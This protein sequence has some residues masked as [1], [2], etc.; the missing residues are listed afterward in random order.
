M[1]WRE[2]KSGE[3]SA[4]DA[5]ELVAGYLAHGQGRGFFEK[6]IGRL[7]AI[8][9]EALTQAATF[10]ADNKASNP[11]ITTTYAAVLS[12]YK[13]LCGVV[14]EQREADGCATCGGLGR[15]V[16]V[17][18]GDDVFSLR[19]LPTGSEA[20]GFGV[21]ATR[22]VPCFCE[23]GTAINRRGN[24][25]L[26]WPF[27]ELRQMW[28][29]HV[30]DEAAADRFCVECRRLAGATVYQFGDADGSAE[31]G[32]CGAA[33]VG[34][35][36]AEPVAATAGAHFGKGVRLREFADSAEGQDSGA[37]RRVGAVREVT[38]KDG[39]WI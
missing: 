26:R 16:L 20:R 3:F 32:P 37:A 28:R 15:G 1:S 22:V 6:E 23:H 30:W 9:R 18:G 27:E 36:P 17:V 8:D 11:N 29:G 12:K 21:V 34:D 4:A 10:V 19:Q 2:K 35:G 5:G 33:G 39:E 14:R 38:E 24:G 7:G 25:S 31:A 13:A